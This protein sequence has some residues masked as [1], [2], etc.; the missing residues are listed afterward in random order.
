MSRSKLFVKVDISEKK[1]SSGKKAAVQRAAPRTTDDAACSRCGLFHPAQS[2]CP[3][4][5]RACRSCGAIGHFQKMC[6]KNKSQQS[7]YGNVGR[8][9]LNRTSVVGTICLATTPV[10][11]PGKTCNLNWLPDTGSDIDA[12]GMD[13]LSHLGCSVSD[14]MEDS[15]VATN[16]NGRTLQSL[17]QMKIAIQCPRNRN[18]S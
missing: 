17:G 9:R 16:A 11:G 7:K 13:E 18:S 6:S 15:T 12:T 4:K 1:H 3:A 14:L 8:L 10:D 2:K 5:D